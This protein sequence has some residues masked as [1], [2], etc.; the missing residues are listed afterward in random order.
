[1]ISRA[2][3]AITSW[4]TRSVLMA[5]QKCAEMLESVRLAKLRERKHGQGSSAHLQLCHPHP[6]RFACPEPR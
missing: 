4:E 6:T 1:M 2:S 5:A 3:F